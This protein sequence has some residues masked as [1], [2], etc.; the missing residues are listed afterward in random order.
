MEKKKLPPGNSN[1]VQ[2]SHVLTDETIEC[3]YYV[4]RNVSTMLFV[5]SKIKKKNLFPGII[6]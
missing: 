6:I 4:L 5:L 2:T 1:G 3:D